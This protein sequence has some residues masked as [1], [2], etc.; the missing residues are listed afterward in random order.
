MFRH[1][2]LVGPVNAMLGRR[3]RSS[4]LRLSTTTFTHRSSSKP[5]QY[6]RRLCRASRMGRLAGYKTAYQEC[7]VI[8]AGGL[9][10]PA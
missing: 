9:E 6:Q 10:M 8:T 3:G 5:S 2:R 4:I 1:T 7:G